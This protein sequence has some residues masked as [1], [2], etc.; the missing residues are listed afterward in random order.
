[1]PLTRAKKIAFASAAAVLIAASLVALYFSLGSDGQTRAHLLQLVPSDATAVIFVDLDEL[2]ASPFLAKL[3]TWAPQL[4]EDSEYAQFVRDSGFSYERDLRRVALAISNHGS[5]TN[6]FA[7]ADGI[8]DRKKIEAFFS[9]SGK[10][11][12][13]GKWKVFQLNAAPNEE[14]FSFAFLGSGRIAVGDSE[15]FLAALSS[16][17]NGSSQSEW[18]ARFERL[19]G[20]PFFAV[21]RQDS[22]LQRAFTS[23]APGGFRSPQLAS[24]LAQLQ[25]IS[26]A[27]KPDG[28]QLRVVADGEC[29]DPA[30]ASQLRDFLQGILLLAQNGL[31]DPKLR[32]KMNPEERQAYL[33]IIRSADI[34]KIDRGEWKS[35]RLSVEITPAF[36]DLARLSTAVAPAEPTAPAPE[37]SA[38]TARPANG[39]TA[40]SGKKK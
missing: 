26:V 2:R 38:K 3:Y 35:V 21:I 5:T 7:V 30:A 13:Q 36:L 39:E 18:T 6:L 8:F 28:E 25:W 24:L 11:R 14:P 22:A 19:A 17:Q 32:Q 34:Q 4:K 40:T 15:N 29:L 20:S 31:H 16:M 23:A 10:S 37:K 9:R 27:G 33:E 12:Q 1:M